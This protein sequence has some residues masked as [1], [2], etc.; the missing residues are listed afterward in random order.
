MIS[1]FY[2][3]SGQFNED[4]I[5]TVGFNMR[6]VTKGNVSIKVSKQY[7]V[8][9]HYFLLAMGHRRSTKIPKHV[10]EILQ[11]R[12]C[13]S[14]SLNW[15]LWF[16]GSSFYF[17]FSSHSYMVDAADLEKIESSKTELQMLLDKPQLTG[18]PV[19]LYFM[20]LPS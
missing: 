6:K 19:R 16:R 1:P 15:L 5:P 8:C 13:Y 4:M 10:G 11:G 20:S 12:N 3:K 17:L 9:L 7:I 2:I 14:V 18:I